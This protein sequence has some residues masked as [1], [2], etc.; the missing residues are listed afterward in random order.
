[1]SAEFLGNSLYPKFQIVLPCVNFKEAL[2]YIA[3]VKLLIKTVD[4]VPHCHR[5][6]CIL[7]C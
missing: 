2:S 4:V 6:V 5:N 7:E 3:E 1:M